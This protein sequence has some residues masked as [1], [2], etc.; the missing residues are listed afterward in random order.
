MFS[1]S[2]GGNTMRIIQDFNNNWKFTKFLPSY[3]LRDE[4]VV[5]EDVSLPH[6]YNAT[7]CDGDKRNFKRYTCYEKCFHISKA[8]MDKKI[9]LYFGAAYTTAYVYMNGKP[10]GSHEG[11]YSAF[12]LEISDFVSFDT[13]NHLTVEVMNGTLA[14]KSGLYCDAKLIMTEKNH[15]SLTGYSSSGVKI[16]TQ[17]LTENRADV[18]I[19][20]K[21]DLKDNP[22]LNISLMAD[23]FDTNGRFITSS[24]TPIS[25]TPLNLFCDETHLTLYIPNPVLWNGKKNQPLYTARIRLIS[26]GEILDEVNKSFGIN[27][28]LNTAFFWGMSNELCHMVRYIS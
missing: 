25:R 5:W 3:S 13:E 19:S 27:N 18:D 15:I 7:P 9:F 17:N 16:T 28:S 6:T 21:T 23:I 4:E 2:K 26:K 20:I 10:V 22:A 14:A 11:G 1:L 12:C 24:S 8:Y